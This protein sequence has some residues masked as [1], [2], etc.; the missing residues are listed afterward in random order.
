MAFRKEKA[1]PRPDWIKPDTWKLI[2]QRRTHLK[3]ARSLARKMGKMPWRQKLAEWNAMNSR[4]AALRTA[5]QERIRKPV[6]ADRKTF[7]EDK[8]KLAQA[9]N[10]E[11]VERIRSVL[12]YFRVG[13]LGDTCPQT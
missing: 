8:S 5:L 13:G 4:H 12:R 7:L 11:E 9:C 10:A 6:K 1:M 3:L 2:K